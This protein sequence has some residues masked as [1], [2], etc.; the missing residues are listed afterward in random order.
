MHAVADAFAVTLAAAALQF[1]LGNEIVTSVIPGPR[2]KT[3]LQQIVDWFS[4]PISGEF[5]ATL[6]SKGLIDGATPVPD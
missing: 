2:D 3:E 5:W 6:K 4:T 1:P